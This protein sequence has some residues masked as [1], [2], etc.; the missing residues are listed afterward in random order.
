MEKSSRAV[1][2]QASSFL[3]HFRPSP[4]LRS[5][6]APFS[7]L[8]HCQAG[9][10]VLQTPHVSLSPSRAETV[11]HPTRYGIQYPPKSVPFLCSSSCCPPVKLQPCPTPRCSIQASV[12][13]LSH[14]FAWRLACGL[15][16][17]RIAVEA[18]CCPAASI[19]CCHRC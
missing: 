4:S 6:P 1:S 19:D 2:L 14:P 11:T 8:G 17:S 13:C 10:G 7:Y 12:S 15:L 9:P 18:S 3:Q 16:A 5:R